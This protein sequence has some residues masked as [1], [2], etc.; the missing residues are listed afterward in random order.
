MFPQIILSL[1]IYLT[2]VFFKLK[3]V[4]L[5]KKKSNLW[6]E[7]VKSTHDNQVSQIRK[8]IFLI[9]RGFLITSNKGET[10][11]IPNAPL[12]AFSFPEKL[13]LSQYKLA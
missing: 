6:F 1:K 11:L 4:C 10:L 7:C 5:D 2:G 3:D 13:Q 8:Y 12:N 9:T